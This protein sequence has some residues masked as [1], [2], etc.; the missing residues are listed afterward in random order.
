MDGM[1]SRTSEK[2][3]F[4]LF[5]ST[6]RLALRFL[7]GFLWFFG[8]GQFAAL[9][10]RPARFV[11]L[12][13]AGDSQSIGG[14]IFRDGRTC[15]G[16]RAITDAHGRDQGSVAAAENFAAHPGPLLVEAVVISRNHARAYIALASDL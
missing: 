3:S 1:Q 16:V 2:L 14:D 13:A 5:R 12:A 9:L 11:D 7:R 8:G 6:P 10:C 15:G 4:A